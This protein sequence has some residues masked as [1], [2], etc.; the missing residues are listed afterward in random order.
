M[1]HFILHL[2]VNLL[3]LAGGVLAGYIYGSHE[4]RKL[5]RHY[6]DAIQTRI[7]QMQTLLRISED[8]RI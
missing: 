8:E 7:H 1:I 2:T 4:S 3:C 6:H 5:L